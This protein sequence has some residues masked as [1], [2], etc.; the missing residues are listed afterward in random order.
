ML[1][2]LLYQAELSLEEEE[3]AK[4]KEIISR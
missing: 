2:A 4:V 3:Q 1:S